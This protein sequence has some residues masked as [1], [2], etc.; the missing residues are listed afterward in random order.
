MCG[1]VEFI[2][3][4]QKGQMMSINTLLLIT[5]ALLILADGLKNI[6]KL[7]KEINVMKNIY[8]GSQ[9]VNLAKM[10]GGYGLKT[11]FKCTI[12]EIY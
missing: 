4:Y 12:I 6:C 5:G 11:S 10:P 8:K 7:N 9:D 1:I 3:L 2:N